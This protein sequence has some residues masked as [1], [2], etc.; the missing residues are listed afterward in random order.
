M[1][2]D[3]LQSYEVLQHSGTENALF[4]TLRLYD[5]LS[6]GIL[7][8]TTLSA[9][10]HTLMDLES[11]IQKR[12]EGMPW[13]Y[14]LGRAHFMGRMFV[15]S[16]D[17]LIPTDETR[18]LVDAVLGSLLP[19]EAGN[20][21]LK[22]IEVGTG[23]GNIAIS[24]AL[25]TMRTTILA[26]DISS[27]A[28]EVARTN[29]ARFKMQDRVS[30]FCG[31]LFAPFAGRGYEENIDVVVCNP[32]YIPTGSLSKLSHE[33]LDFEPHVALDGGPYGIDIYR[34]LIA[35]SLPLLRP[36]GM[37]FFEIGERQEKIVTRI[38]EKTNGYQD[39]DYFK[40]G[41]TIRAIRATKK[42][43]PEHAD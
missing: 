31:D 37:L 33:I 25:H 17:T 6:G 30:L 41:E 1:F 27:A 28:V 42:R 12:K 40:D 34:R 43:T 23:C 22:L 13:E 26:S 21:D 15:C 29:V 2:H 36:G 5:L 38:L 9:P 7:R 19:Q 20:A 24:L 35:E 14:I 8:K 18:V 32:P 39:I 3:M 10:D 4:E 16:Q 11:A